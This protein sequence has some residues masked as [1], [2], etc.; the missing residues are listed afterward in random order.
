[1][2]ENQNKMNFDMNNE[3]TVLKNIRPQNS[4]YAQAFGQLLGKYNWQWFVV[5]TFDAQCSKEVMM[6]RY[7]LWRKQIAKTER[8]QLG[9]ATV[10]CSHP[11]S[12]LHSVMVGLSNQS[13]KTL[14]DVDRL[15]WKAA[16]V[17]ANVNYKPL[18]M[19]ANQ[20]E[21]VASSFAASSYLGHNAQQN[22]YSYYISKPKFLRKFL[23]A[24][25]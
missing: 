16:W 10:L 3:I 2:N 9:Y 12:H 7:L 23:T 5:L 24:T 15:K 17:Q 6:R 14:W 22:D 21:N 18:S 25:A 4:P 13:G 8:I 19:K 20:I 1:M 11:H